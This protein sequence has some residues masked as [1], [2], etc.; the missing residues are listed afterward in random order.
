MCVKA[1]GVDPLSPDGEKAQL[2]DPKVVEALQFAGSIY[3]DQGGFSRAKAFRDS[4]D[5]F[6]KGNQFVTGVL[7]AMPVADVHPHRAFAAHPPRAG[8]DRAVRV[9][10]GVDPT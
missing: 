1:N 7:G 3:E 10:G 9:P 4:A 6:G 2:N 8:G 5:F